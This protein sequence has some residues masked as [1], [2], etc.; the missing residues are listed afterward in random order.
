MH[1]VSRITGDGR[2]EFFER[3]GGVGL[4]RREGAGFGGVK[5]GDETQ[6]VHTETVKSFRVQIGRLWNECI[7]LSCMSGKSYNH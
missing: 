2:A 4:D 7:S 5:T 1:S 3:R 6:Y